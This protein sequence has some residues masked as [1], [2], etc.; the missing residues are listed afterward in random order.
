LETCVS[1]TGILIV[2]R[3]GHHSKGARILF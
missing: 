2:A 3:T 1:G